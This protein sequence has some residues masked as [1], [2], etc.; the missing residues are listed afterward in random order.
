MIITR[1]LNY[2]D[3]DA[4]LH[5][6]REKGPLQY[7]GAAVSLFP[8]FTPTVQEAR[9]KFSEVQ[10]TLRSLGVRYGTLHP[11][12]TDGDGRYM[13]V[14]GLLDSCKI[15]LLNAYAPNIDAPEFFQDIHSHIGLFHVDHVLVRGDFNLAMDTAMDTT[16]HAPTSKPCSL[17]ALKDLCNT[18]TLLDLWRLFGTDTLAY[19]FLSVYHGTWLCIDYWLFTSAAAQWITAVRHLPQT[20]SDHSPVLITLSVPATCGAREVPGHGTVGR[21]ILRILKGSNG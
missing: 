4:A 19:T 10:A 15:L 20:R 8:D 3:R 2:R 1:L 16:S 17:R 14:A 5:L 18:F 13:M 9:R 6:A 11:A 21:S 12:R 7:Q